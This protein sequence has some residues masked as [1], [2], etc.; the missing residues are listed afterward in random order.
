MKPSLPPCERVGGERHANLHL[1][2]SRR[3]VRGEVRWRDERE[4]LRGV[5]RRPDR[6]P[7]RTIFHRLTSMRPA[8]SQVEQSLTNA[9]Y[10]V[11]T[12]VPSG[13]RQA[14]AFRRRP[15]GSCT[16]RRKVQ[17]LALRIEQPDTASHPHHGP[18]GD[19]MASR[20]GEGT[21]VGMSESAGYGQRSSAQ[22]PGNLESA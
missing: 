19:P 22:V 10:G 5:F 4:L 7:I 11:A 20:P 18:P 17:R 12:V 9:V 3:T 1:R 14:G 13:G 16:A 21:R 6:R 15:P 2:S 8:S